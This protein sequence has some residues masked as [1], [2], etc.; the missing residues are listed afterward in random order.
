MA[1]FYDFGVRELY[2]D[3]CYHFPSWEE[4]VIDYYK[5]GRE[6]LTILMRGDEVLIYHGPTHGIRNARSINIEMEEERWRRLF[7]WHLARRIEEQYSNYSVFADKIGISRVML[8]RYINGHA[9]P[10]MYVGARIASALGC[11]MTELCDLE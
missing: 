6:E 5:S 9:T 1:D 4:R 7:G 3:F 11:S 8:S 10:S 2:S